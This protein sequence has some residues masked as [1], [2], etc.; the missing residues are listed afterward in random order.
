M[1]DINAAL[2]SM[3]GSGTFADVMYWLGYGVLSILLLAAFGA[4]YYFLT[5]NHKV[6]VFPIY[7]SGKDGIFSV[8]K[9]RTNRV[10]WIKNQTAWRKMYPLFNRKEI[11]PFDQEYIYPGKRIYAFEL[12]NEWVPG[13]VNINKSED[14]LR[15]EL[16]PVPYS[17]RN[18]QGLQ[19]QKNAVE[20]SNPGWWDENKHL[21]LGVLT[22][23]ICVAG[24]LIA[25]WFT[26]EYLAPGRA[27]IAAFTSAIKNANTAPVIGPH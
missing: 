25:I 9:P 20:Y 10:K 16:N 12:N 11:E 18:W 6:M 17:V 23:G 1:V 4:A 22:V 3:V 21:V 8:Q 24:M 5:F 13:R 26:Y 7:G 15:A 27:D 19:Y 14:S 2:S